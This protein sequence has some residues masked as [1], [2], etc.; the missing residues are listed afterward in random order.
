MK[1][2]PIEDKNIQAC[3]DIYNYYI[4]NTCNTLE[5]EP[6]TC[7]IFKKRV[8]NITKKYPYIV[9]ENDDD[10]VLGY[11]YLH[12]FHE[13]SAYRKTVELSIYVD[14]D[15]LHEHLG[16]TLFDEILSLAKKNGFSNI[17][18]IV[19]SENAPSVTFH[20]KNSFLLEGH[21][22]HVAYKMKKD[23]DVYYFRREI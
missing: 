21:L 20:E 17:I 8:D 10:T 6:V 3:V 19:T 23:L 9:I 4:L 11:A 12:Q 13:R 2:V 14:K 16:Q 15:H 1:I 5:E 7:S 22:K 18:S